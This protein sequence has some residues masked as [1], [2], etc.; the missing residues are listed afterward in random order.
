MRTD[1]PADVPTDLRGGGAA[2]R[3]AR[4]AEV[5]AHRALGTDMIPAAVG[6]PGGCHGLFHT[7]TTCTKVT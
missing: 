4:R 1:P 7:V 6:C 3:R 2:R 5:G